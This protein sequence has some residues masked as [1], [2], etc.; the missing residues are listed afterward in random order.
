VKLAG[1][2]DDS[3]VGANLDEDGQDKLWRDKTGQFKIDQSRRRLD[4][5][6]APLPTLRVVAGPDILRFCSVFPQ[7]LVTIGR[8]PSCDLTLH[9]SSV[10]RQNT[11]V[12]S[13]AD[14]TLTLT[15]LDSTNGTLRNGHR[16]D[17]PVTIQPGDTIEIGN[18]ML[19]IDLMTVNE[20]EQL[21]RVLERLNLAQHDSLTGAMAR[22]FLT[23]ELPNLIVRHRYAE[24]PISLFF[25]DLDHF[26]S[27]NDTF[28]HGLGDDVL[29]RTVKEFTRVLRDSDICIRYGGEEFVVVLPGCNLNDAHELSEKLR[30]Q[31]E[32]Y[33][34]TQ[35][36]ESISVTVSIGV[37]ALLPEESLRDW[38]DRADRAMYVAKQSG[39]NKT[40]LA[41]TSSE[42][43]P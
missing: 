16:I 30:Q 2:F 5:H 3:T 15:D 40:C 36:H 12:Q 27:I 39:R 32:Q 22:S 11:T 9:D 7:E 31:I 20:L 24:N 23:D 10:S 6:K 8:D 14:G 34:W 4:T 43:A 26:K 25:I 41:Q 29:V 28:G 19:R 1:N 42:S 17:E 35:L 38:I 18:V 13:N 21:G 33:D 37:A